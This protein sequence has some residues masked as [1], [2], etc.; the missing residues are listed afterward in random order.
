MMTIALSRQALMM[1][2][3]SAALAAA[4]AGPAAAQSLSDLPQEL[5]A[6]YTDGIPV[7]PSAYDDF[8]MPSKPWKWCHSESY[9]GNPW[10]V[11]MANE[12]KRLVEGAKTAGLVSEFEMSD[13]NGDVTQQIAQIRAFMD[14]GC[15]VITMI[16]GSSTAL[17]DVI[18]AS[19]KAGIPVVTTASA[20]TSPYALNIQHNHN[21][22]GYNMG[23]GVAAYLNGPGNVLM[24]EGIPGSPIVAQENSG[25]ERAFKEHPDITIVGMVSGNWTANVTKSV[26]LQTLATNPA[27]ID[28]VWTTGSETRVV[29]EAFEEAGRPV[30]LVTGSMSGDALG[31]WKEHKDTFKFYGGAILPTVAAQNTYRAATRLLEGQQPLVN[32]IIVPVPEIK[33]EDLDK[34]AA[35]CMTVESGSIFPVPPSDPISEQM[36]DGYFR[37]GAGSP[38]YDFA[39]TPNPCG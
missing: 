28:A 10:R 3:G 30:P 19:Y 25:G 31:Y 17:N 18:E 38:G 8:K 5:Q 33:Q 11:N 16:A 4:A 22:W 35:P 12:L 29:A 1:A 14:K 21:V 26:V 36:L 20:V 15:S 7:G 32:T 24:V 34:W 9:M 2:L 27:Q 37:K 23:K 39:S 6:L 13:S